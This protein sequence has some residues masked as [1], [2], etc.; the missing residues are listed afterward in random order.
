[1]ADRTTA[2]SRSPMTPDPDWTAFDWLIAPLDRVTFLDEAWER[3]PQAIHRAD[4]D[5]LLLARRSRPTSTRS[6]ATFRVPADRSGSA[7]AAEVRLVRFLDGGRG[8][9]RSLPATTAAQTCTSC[10]ARYAA[11]WTVV[12]GPLGGRW[13]PITSLC[14]RLETALHH[15]VSANLYLTPPER[16]GVPT[17]RRHPRRVHRPGR[18]RQD[19]ADRLDR[20]ASCRSVDAPFHDSPRRHRTTPRTCGSTPATCCICPAA[21]CTRRGRRRFHRCTSRSASTSPDGQIW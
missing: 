21:G 16:A 13:P 2:G 4:P 20:A 11:G 12:I 8:S 19:V 10:I 3:R 17:P 14:A 6:P 7:P 9:S 15:R 1:M 18:R 5:V